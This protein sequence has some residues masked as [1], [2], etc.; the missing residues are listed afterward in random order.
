VAAPANN[1]GG[2]SAA[3]LPS[4]GKSAADDGDWFAKAAQAL[5]PHKAGTALHYA[6]GFD[7]RACQRYAAGSIKPP[8]Y[9]LRALLRSDGGWQW[10]AAL[11][12][13]ADPQWWRDIQRARLDSELLRRL[14]DDIT[15][16]E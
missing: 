1:H 11:M 12:D 2:I 15:T 8:A 14:V 7:E 13:G 16:R 6:T 5:L 3:G 9:F 10:L 4:D